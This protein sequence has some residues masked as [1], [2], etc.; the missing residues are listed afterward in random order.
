MAV[1]IKS[2][3]DE[4][5]AEI[6]RVN[7]TSILWNL[8]ADFTLTRHMQIRHGVSFKYPH[9]F[10]DSGPTPDD[11]KWSYTPQG[12]AMQEWINGNIS[13]KYSIQMYDVYFEDYDDALLCYL[14]FKD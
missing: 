3:S 5:G 6:A 10:I 9:R 14:R 11:V 12:L 7:L 13:G 2:Y 8:A 1:S 4:E